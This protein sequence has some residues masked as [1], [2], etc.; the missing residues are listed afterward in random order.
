MNAE[1]YDTVECLE[2]MLSVHIDKWE[3]IYGKD[4]REGTL[5]RRFA[6]V[7]E[8]AYEKTGK[9]VVVLVEERISINSSDSGRK[10]FVYIVLV[11]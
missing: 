3:D 2:L 8:R 9:R 7:I 5:S 1:K 6:G 4:N 10:K 11:L